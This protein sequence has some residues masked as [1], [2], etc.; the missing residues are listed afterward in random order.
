MTSLFVFS[1]SVRGS[2][3]DGSPVP[4]AG[5]DHWVD[6][7]RSVCLFHCWW[8][9]GLL[10]LQGSRLGIEEAAERGPAISL[11]HAGL[12]QSPALPQTSSVTLGK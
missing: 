8:A 12:T 7:A 3:R 9:A 1:V 10:R 4:M 11:S 5:V 6:R 2:H